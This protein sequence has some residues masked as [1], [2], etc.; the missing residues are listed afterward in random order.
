MPFKQV[1]GDAEAAAPMVHTWR[2]IGNCSTSQR[3]QQRLGVLPDS[4]LVKGRHHGT[5]I[6]TLPTPLRGSHSLRKEGIT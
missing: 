4:T 6:S 3:K 5:Q 1:P 2:D